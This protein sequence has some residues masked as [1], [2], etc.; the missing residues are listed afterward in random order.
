MQKIGV[1]LMLIGVVCFVFFVGLLFV[2]GLVGER[3]HYHQSVIDEIKTAHI[4][5]QHLITPFLVAQSDVGER[6]IY[7][8]QSTLDISASVRDDEYRRGIYH[9]I[10][11]QSAVSI[12]QHF[13]LPK[14]TQSTPA[15]HTKSPTPKDPTPKRLTLIISVSDM[16]GVSAKDIIIDGKSYPVQFA[17]EGKYGM[18]YL[19]VD[20]SG[21]LGK[22]GFDSDLTVSVS[23]ID[24]LNVLPL[25]ANFNATLT[26]N[27]HDPKFFGQALP[28]SKN[29]GKAGEGFSASWQGGFIANQNENLLSTCAGG[30]SGVCPNFEAIEHTNYQS[31]GTSFVK[32]NDTYTQTDRSIKYA[33][34]LVMVSFGTF[35]LFEVIKGLKIHPVQ[36][37]LVA[38]ALLVFYLLLLSL[39]EQIAFL[40]AYIIASASCVGLI[41]W[42]ACHLLG[43][44]KRGVAFGVLLGA[45]YGVFY[46]ILSASEMNLLMGS[47]FSFVC[48]AIA[49]VATRHVDWYALKDTKGANA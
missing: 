37:L 18:N 5:H 9:A 25:G 27:W 41:G 22:A 20:L 1:K 26:S 8:S 16:R 15:Q 10:S 39:A 35:F 40:Y 6:L 38:S 2:S 28:I 23:G 32:T 45:L 30:E 21:E 49:M 34:L 7:P 14:I 36:Y 48:I 44:A 33:L 19:T 43:S 47:V 42:Y 13:D 46:V 4:K 31:F 3:E 29:L 24:S 17:K 11:Y 12:K